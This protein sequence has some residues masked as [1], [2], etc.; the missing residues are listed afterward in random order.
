MCYFQQLQNCAKSP[1]P[2]IHSGLKFARPG[3]FWQVIRQAFVLGSKEASLIFL[4][5]PSTWAEVMGQ[6]RDIGLHTQHLG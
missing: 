1:H 5:V 2:N 3:Q 4:T 6:S